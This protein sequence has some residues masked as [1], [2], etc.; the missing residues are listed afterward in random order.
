MLIDVYDFDGTIYNGDSTA[1]LV[2]F[3]LRRH[4]Q[5]LAGLPRIAGAAM[6]LAGKK[7]GLTQFKGI[8]FAEMAKYIDLNTEA[9]LFWLH[10]KTRRKLGAWFNA[11]PR[12]LPIVIASASPEFELTHAA[13]MLGVKTLVG[14]QCD[15][16]TGEI[17][18][19]NCKGEE[20][21]P[22]IREALGCEYTVRAMYTDDAKADGPLL[23]LA[24]EKY[25]VTRGK[26][27]KIG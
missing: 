24:Q 4:P 21:I 13:R 3:C 8:L 7:I 18:G 26:V 9:G 15:P 12:D 10:P 20:K 17:R 27:R 23:A 11:T 2:L 25:L 19:K 6:K 16:Y 14:T 22:R 1:D 5:I